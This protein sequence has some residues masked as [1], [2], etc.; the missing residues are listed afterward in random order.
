MHRIS[1]PCRG[2]AA[3]LAVAGLMVPAVATAATDGAEGWS[4]WRSPPSSGRCGAR[5]TG[6]TLATLD[7]TAGADRK[8]RATGRSRPASSEASETPCTGISNLESMNLCFER[9]GAPASVRP[10]L[11]ANF[12]AEGLSDA[13]VDRALAAARADESERPNRAP[14]VVRV[15]SYN[16]AEPP[17]PRPSDD[18]CTAAAPENCKSVPPSPPT[19][20]IDASFPSA[21]NRSISIDSPP[22]AALLR[23]VGPPRHD[24]VGPADGWD[25]P[26]NRP[27]K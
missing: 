11:I 3:I 26:P 25:S 5:L 27:P 15:L 13:V 19:L 8:E 20:S 9:A 14:A 7:E 1:T 24:P 21:R 6:G 10:H 4:L 23:A 2:I 12:Q 16:P 18:S 17:S 22:R